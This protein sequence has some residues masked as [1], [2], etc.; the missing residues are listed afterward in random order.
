MIRCRLRLDALAAVRKR[1]CVPVAAGDVER[2]RVGAV[3]EQS[4]A[5]LVV[6][7]EVCML[8]APPPASHAMPCHAMP[9]VPH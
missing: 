1:V 4:A 2:A 3:Q 5:A 6:A 9:C 7:A 8:P